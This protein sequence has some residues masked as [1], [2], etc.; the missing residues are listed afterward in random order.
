MATKLL[1]AE[2]AVLTR[3]NVKLT[4]TLLLLTLCSAIPFCDMRLTARRGKSI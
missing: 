1:R 4:Y 2:T 3:F